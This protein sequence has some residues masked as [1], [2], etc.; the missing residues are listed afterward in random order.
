MAIITKQE[1]KVLEEKLYSKSD[2]AE[3]ELA[4]KKTTYYIKIGDN[5]PAIPRDEAISRLGRENWISGLCR[6]A[7]HIKASRITSTGL[8]VYFDSHALCL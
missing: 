2:I 1:K 8:P 6:S 7:F 5:E 3:I 4:A